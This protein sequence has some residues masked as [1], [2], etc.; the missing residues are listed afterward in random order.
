[1]SF[2]VVL[3]N[4]IVVEQD[5]QMHISHGASL[6]KKALLLFVGYNQDLLSKNKYIGTYAHHQPRGYITKSLKNKVHL[7]SL[8]DWLEIPST[9]FWT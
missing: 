4:H 1:M 2:E 5:M 9:Q 8:N 6:A 7:H 3:E